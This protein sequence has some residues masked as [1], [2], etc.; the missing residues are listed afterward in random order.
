MDKFPLF[1]VRMALLLSNIPFT[2]STGSIFSELLRIA[3]CSLRTDDLIPRDFDLFSKMKAQ[4]GN[5]AAL[6]K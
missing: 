1:L 6:P 4:G 3:G 5:R 2:I